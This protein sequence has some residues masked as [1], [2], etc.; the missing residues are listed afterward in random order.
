VLKVIRYIMYEKLS[1]RVENKVSS[2]C[3]RLMIG[4]MPLSD[5]CLFIF[6]NRPLA[7][8]PHI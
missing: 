2:L 6:I 5:I 8:E 4:L 7:T 3:I 1:Y